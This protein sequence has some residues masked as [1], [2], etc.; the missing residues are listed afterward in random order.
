M[1]LLEYVCPSMEL[2]GLVWPFYGLKWHFMVFYGRISSFLVFIDPNSF[3]LVFSYFDF[4]S[5]ADQ[6]KQ[7]FM[8]TLTTT[9]RALSIAKMVL[10]KHY[11][12]LL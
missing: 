11:F 2:F 8:I 3:G 12:K 6:G 4:F 7:S 5:M 10:L 9:N 1:S